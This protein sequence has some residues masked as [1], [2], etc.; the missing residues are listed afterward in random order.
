MLCMLAYVLSQL[1]ITKTKIADGIKL[2]KR[3]LVKVW[4]VITQKYNK[5]VLEFDIRYEHIKTFN[6]LLEMLNS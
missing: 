6:K 4:A 3:K 2:I 5:L 1:I